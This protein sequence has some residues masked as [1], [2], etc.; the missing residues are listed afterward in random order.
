MVEAPPLSDSNSSA[1]VLEQ[2]DVALLLTDQSGETN[3]AGGDQG[4]ATLAERFLAHMQSRGKVA[5]WLSTNT[6]LEDTTPPPVPRFRSPEWLSALRE[7]DN[8]AR[9]HFQ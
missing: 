3:T 1:G 8:A 2:E 9:S 6:A 7:A 4:S 5:W